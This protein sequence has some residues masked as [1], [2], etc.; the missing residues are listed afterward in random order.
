V[1]LAF[2]LLRGVV[3]T[4]QNQYKPS[5]VEPQIVWVFDADDPEDVVGCLDKSRAYYYPTV[6]LFV[7]YGLGEMCGGSESEQNCEDNC[8]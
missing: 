2:D 7:E 4:C 8:R 3:M 5:S 1:G 6:C